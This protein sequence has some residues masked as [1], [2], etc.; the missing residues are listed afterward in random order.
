MKPKKAQMEMSRLFL[1][2]ALA[3]IAFLLISYVGYNLITKKSRQFEQG[4]PKPVLGVLLFAAPFGELTRRFKMGNK[5]GSILG[6][7][8]AVI[9][10]LVMT[11]AVLI[12]VAFA[13]ALFFGFKLIK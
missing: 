10:S 2:L 7:P 13:V 12:I 11:I 1:Y 4:I 9:A 3:I 8:P 5:K 6:L